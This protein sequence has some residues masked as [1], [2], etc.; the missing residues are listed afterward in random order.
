MKSESQHANFLKAW[1]EKP[2]RDENDYTKISKC[3]ARVYRKELC[4]SLFLNFIHMVFKM[5]CPIL[6]KLIVDY[7]QSP[8][9]EDGG[10]EYGFLLVFTYII[11]DI[12]GV[13]LEEQA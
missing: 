11:V 3:I 7:M 13:I 4:L 2:P 12:L 8:I 5:C 1:E 10:I 6:I 9:G